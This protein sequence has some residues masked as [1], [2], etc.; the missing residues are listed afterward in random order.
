MVILSEFPYNKPYT[1]PRD[2]LSNLERESK[3]SRLRILH[4]KTLSGFRN[5]LMNYHD[6]LFLDCMLSVKLPG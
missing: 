3:I 6:Y 5:Q 1:I 4:G 2:T